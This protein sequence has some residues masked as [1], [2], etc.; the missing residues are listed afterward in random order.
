[1]RH[2]D[3]NARIKHLHKVRRRLSDGSWHFLYYHR[4][5]GARLPDPMDATFR[6]AYE[7]QNRS[8][9]A[10]PSAKP[11]GETVMLE[12]AHDQDVS[13]IETIS[14]LLLTPEEV[15]QRYRGAVSLGTLANWRAM[16]IGPAYT[17][18]HKA[19][20]YPIS[21]LI[22]WESANTEMCD[23]PKLLRVMEAE[24]RAV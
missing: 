22:L 12:K 18:L 2:L 9:V 19:I 11:I 24:D 5:T 6:D 14:D 21:L 13:A 3:S 1:M 17:K 23:L 16:K 15:T 7:A 10:A 8:I 4:L 20:L